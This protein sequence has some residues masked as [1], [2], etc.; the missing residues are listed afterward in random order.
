[1][2]TSL[3]A[4]VNRPSV[5]TKLEKPQHHMHADA[6]PASVLTAD[7]RIVRADNGCEIAL[8]ELAV[9]GK[10]PIVWTLNERGR[11]AAG[12]MGVVSQRGSC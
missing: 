1:V 10:R 3:T 8:G 11:L 4:Q 7:A 5:D 6:V 9:T 2:G 12:A